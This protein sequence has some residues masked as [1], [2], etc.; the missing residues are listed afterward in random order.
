M[1]ESGQ[2]DHLRSTL[3]DLM[4]WFEGE[5]LRAA[6]I[7][8]VA[9]GL[10]GEPRLTED[11][12]AVTLDIGAE[13]LIASGQ[14]YGFVPRVEDA[15]EFSHRTR[16]LLMKHRSGVNLDLSLGALPFEFEV[17]ERAQRVDVGGGVEITIASPEDLI[18][19]KALARRVQDMADIAGII[20][21]QPEL[22][23]ERIRRWVR[24][25]ASVLDMPEVFEDLEAA[26]KRRQR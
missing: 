22:D 19:M 26:L 6:V 1:S 10:H 4:R 11:V 12:D 18:I 21:A 25:F 8:G 14:R 2:I 23:V 13:Q 5:H 9:A 24:E 17:V 15:L 7:G 20:D 16:V 3:S